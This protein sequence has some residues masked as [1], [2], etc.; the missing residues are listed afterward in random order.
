MLYLSTLV[1]F[2]NEKQNQREKCQ[3]DVSNWKNKTDIMRNDDA[4]HFEYNNP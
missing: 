3:N 1:C 2:G 4:K